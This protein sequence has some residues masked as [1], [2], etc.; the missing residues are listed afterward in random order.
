LK[1]LWPY[2]AGTTLARRSVVARRIQ[3]PNRYPAR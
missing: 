1:M 3:T 2:S